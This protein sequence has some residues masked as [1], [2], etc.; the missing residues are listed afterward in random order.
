MKNEI[1]HWQISLV[2]QT[3]QMVKQP[4]KQM[5]TE[6]DGH[7]DGV[8]EWGEA[9]SISRMKIKERVSVPD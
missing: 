7:T 1:F 6:T 2:E 9:D 5:Q 4:P 3:D 8:T